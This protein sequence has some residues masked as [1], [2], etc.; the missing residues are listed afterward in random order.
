M[1]RKHRRLQSNPE[2]DITAFLNLMIVLVPVLLL[3]MV[4]TQLR[5][6]DLDFPG[7]APGQAPDK[8]NFQLEVLVLPSGLQVA[9]SD[10]GTIAS[11]SARNGKYDFEGLRDLLKRIKKRMPDKTDVT[12]R[13]G[14]DVDYQL[15]VNTIDAVRSYS[16]VVAASLVNAELFPDVALGD[17]PDDAVISDDNASSATP[18]EKTRESGKNGEGAQ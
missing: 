1:R 8:E 9:D 5:I 10:R 2:L 17:A 13:V 16:G 4:F 6:I 14:A 15:L 18:P 12:L 11:F 7:M 3:G